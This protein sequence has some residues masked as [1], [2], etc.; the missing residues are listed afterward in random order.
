MT[1][2][3]DVTMSD[4]ACHVSESQPTLT[5]S[6]T[7]AVGCASSPFVDENRTIS[8]RNW[9][10]FN[11]RG[12][13]CKTARRCPSIAAILIIYWV[14]LL[15]GMAILGIVLGAIK[16]SGD[17]VIGNSDVVRVTVVDYNV[18]SVRL[19]LNSN[20]TQSQRDHFRG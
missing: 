4:L 11:N 1:S 13:N 20:I 12:N 10:Q 15:M 5:D 16:N 18:D 17:V 6:Y 2:N 3:H 7:R 8:P 19:T 9:F 14:L